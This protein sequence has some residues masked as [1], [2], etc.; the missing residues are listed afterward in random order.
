MG[1][2]LYLFILAVVLV[3]VITSNTH[4][5]VVESAP[6]SCQRDS[7][8]TGQQ[9]QDVDWWLII[10]LSMGDLYLYYDSDMHE[11][12]FMQGKF[13]R[14]R[15]SAFGQ[16]LKTI[17]D[18]AID[19]IGFNNDFGHQSQ[20][21]NNPFGEYNHEKGMIAW[22][23]E[24]AIY[25]QH[26]IPKFPNGG[27]YFKQNKVD[28]FFTIDTQP[29][30]PD[31]E[32]SLEF[33]RFS[34]LGWPR[35]IDGGG[36][37]T[38]FPSNIMGSRTCTS[39]GPGTI[40]QSKLPKIGKMLQNFGFP[41]SV[42]K[43]QPQDTA[44]VLKSA[45]YAQHIFCMS[46]DAQNYIMPNKWNDMPKDM[47]FVTKTGIP[48]PYFSYKLLKDVQRDGV[49][50]KVMNHRGDATKKIYA[51][52]KYQGTKKNLWADSLF[53]ADESCDPGNDDL[54]VNQPCIP[55]WVEDIPPLTLTAYNL[56]KAFDPARF[57]F[58]KFTTTFVQGQSSQLFA[59]GAGYGEEAD[60]SK[61]GILEDENHPN[62]K[63]WNVC[64]SGS[65]L[66][67]TKGSVLICLKKDSLVEAFKNLQ[68]NAPDAQRSLVT[69]DIWGERITGQ[70]QNWLAKRSWDPEGDFAKYF[71]D[72]SAELV[73]KA[74]KNPLVKDPDS[75]E[76]K[77]FASQPLNVQILYTTIIEHY[78]FTRLK[79]PTNTPLT[80]L[81][82]FLT[83]LGLVKPE[84]P[85]PVPL[86]TRK[87]PPI[88]II[89]RAN[90]N[91]AIV[92]NNKPA[93]VKRLA[94]QT[95][96]NRKVEEEG[97][98]KKRFK[99]EEKR[100]VIEGIMDEMDDFTEGIKSIQKMVD[101]GLEQAD[102][103]DPDLIW[104]KPY[105]VEKNLQI[106]KLCDAFYQAKKLQLEELASKTNLYDCDDDVEIPIETDTT[107]DDGQ[108]PPKP[109]D[110][111]MVEEKSDPIIQLVG[112]TS[113]KD[114]NDRCN[115][116]K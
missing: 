89:H 24:Q 41:D 76:P 47:M 71:Q 91:A 30:Y 37:Y 70:V 96:N 104:I 9:N 79:N 12:Q 15:Y 8:L 78:L 84:M 80:T 97:P 40:Y 58:P 56:G 60:H 101:F 90:A 20:V 62:Y 55:T 50:K 111:I 109:Q 7:L 19:Y 93:A 114:I 95:T 92:N 32:D 1:K 103:D 86:Q 106:Q 77:M 45:S 16:A 33:L 4:V 48:Q 43:P 21:K 59:W 68:V 72:H 46:L 36:Y 35:A 82:A 51:L 73:C 105:F 100:A 54:E 61:I 2:S 25:I 6:I 10:K 53:M 49:Y 11:H 17:E 99:T 83:E 107:P 38:M 69:G 94:S 74:I 3:V 87:Q 108:D 42:S 23:L 57:K 113:K 44:N 18:D 98:P 75:F 13:L 110:T 67:Q 63:I 65:N 28:K 27:G 29:D 116:S 52:A 34:L 26:S 39:T 112:P 64:F 5:V 85:V 66:Q 31:D 81:E 14:S 102:D 88:P 115:Q 22:D